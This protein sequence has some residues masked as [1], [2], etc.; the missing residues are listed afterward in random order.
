[1]AESPYQISN[2]LGQQIDSEPAFAPLFDVSQTQQLIN[3]YNV[4]PTMFSPEELEK[5]K[6]HAYYHQVPMYEGEFTVGE[7]FKQFAQ[8]VFSGFTTFNVGKPP[9]NEYEGIARSI[10]HLVGFA[11]GMVARPFIK[12]KATSGW[13]QKLAGIKSVPMWTAGK[14][15]EK[16]SAIVGPAIKTAVDGKA[17]AVGTV[18]KFLTSK[19]ATHIM[20]GAFDLGVASGLN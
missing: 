3:Q 15:R 12:L 7:A 14:I 20:E 4:S 8:G 9:D 5:I 16:A 19:R 13:A 17:G 2:T 11:P 1:M 6:K 18:G 10:G